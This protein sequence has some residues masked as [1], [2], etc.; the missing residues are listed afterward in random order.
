MCEV[1]AVIRWATVSLGLVWVFTTSTGAQAWDYFGHYIVGVVAWDQM[2]EATRRA[3][4]GLLLEAPPDADL[5]SLLP[6]GPR[7]I[8]VRRR[9]LF[10]KANGW[11]DLIRDELFPDRKERYD[12]PAW[13]YVNRFWKSTAE[14]PVAL[15]ERGTM[16]DL[17]VT[18]ERLRGSLVDCST[19]TARSISLGCS[20]SSETCIS[21]FI[22]AA[23]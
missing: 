13:H 20:T 5:A 22:R 3:V 4:V 18:L 12:H 19:P 11:A 14:G 21:P 2:D 17:V 9:E 7:S 23:V 16:G 10:L 15:E 1:M 6:P 8:E